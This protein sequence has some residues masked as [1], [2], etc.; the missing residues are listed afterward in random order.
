MAAVVGGVVRRVS[1]RLQLH[2]K[3]AV[4]P[5]ATRPISDIVYTP[6]QYRIRI[7]DMRVAS[8]HVFASR[9]ANQNVAL[10]CHMS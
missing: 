6:T 2:E 4:R 9:R 3:K 8:R 7:R 5:D 10:M 1:S